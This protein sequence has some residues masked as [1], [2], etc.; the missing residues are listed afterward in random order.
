MVLRGKGLDDFRREML[1]DKRIR[2]IV[3]Y[4]N[5]REVFRVLTLQAEPAI[6]CGTEIIRELAKLPISVAEKK[7]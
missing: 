7:I 6:S 2:K 1:N 3:D 4:D 5:F